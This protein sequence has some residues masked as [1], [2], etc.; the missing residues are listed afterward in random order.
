M[1]DKDEIA[2][3]LAQKH[4][5]VE[6]GISKIYRLTSTPSLEAYPEEPIKLLEVN[7]DTIPA[8]I[9]PLGFDPAPTNGIPFSCVI[10]EVTPA[11]MDRIQARE[12]PLP[13]GWTLGP[14]LPREVLM[15]GNQ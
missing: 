4:Y 2:N 5:Q 8:G 13:R 9:M 11:E 3:Q 15:N 1:P 12:L 6:P 14:L 10:I 7:E